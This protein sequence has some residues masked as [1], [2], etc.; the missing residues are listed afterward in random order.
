MPLAK[1]ILHARQGRRGSL[2]GILCVNW[3]GTLLNADLHMPR[4]YGS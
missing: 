2:H 4:F 3:T 1:T